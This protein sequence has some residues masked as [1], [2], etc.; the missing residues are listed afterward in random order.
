MALFYI[1]GYMTY[2]TYSN[3]LL[4]DKYIYII[5][6]FILNVTRNT[7]WFVFG[8]PVMSCG[9]GFFLSWDFINDNWGYIINHLIGS[10]H[11]TK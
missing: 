11:F 2:R 4:I 9:M 6:T 1:D 7:V 8:L 5:Y 3:C 10:I